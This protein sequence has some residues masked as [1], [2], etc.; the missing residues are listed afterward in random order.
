MRW[1]L[2]GDMPHPGYNELVKL[3]IRLSSLVGSPKDT[4]TSH[5]QI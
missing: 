5:Q 3:Y 1:E 2:V 4:A